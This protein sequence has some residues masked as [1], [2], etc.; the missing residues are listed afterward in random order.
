M[1][2]TRSG[3]VVAAMVVIALVF[4]CAGWVLAALEIHCLDVGQG[5]CTL[6]VS[7]TGGTLLFD[8][9]ENGKGTSEVRPYLQ[10]L[11]LTG[12]DYIAC[13]HYHV[14]HIGGIDEVVSYLGIDSVRVACYDRGWSYTTATYT[15]Y[16]NAVAPKR[17]T[18]SDSQVIDLGGGVTVTCVGL[19]GNGQ[20]SPPFDDKYDENDLCVALLVEY[21]GFKFFVAGDLSGT[22]SSSYHDIET[23]MGYEIGDIDVY[24]VDHHGSASNSNDTFLSTIEPEAAIISVGSNSYGH[25]TQTVINRLVNHDAYIY[26]TELGSGGTIPPGKGEVVGGDVVIIVDAGTYTIDGDVY[27]LAGSGVAGT[28]T[29]PSLRIFPNPFGASTT[30]SFAGAAAGPVR[31]GVYD[32]SGRLVSLLAGSLDATSTIVWNGESS[33]GKAVPPGVYFIRAESAAGTVSRKLVKR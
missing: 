3:F 25:P 14:D 10:S 24:R 2:A 1:K 17:L 15:S 22:N 5:D 26:Q 4:G 29:L 23:S 30:F 32:V 7:P 11:G 20:L 33:Q 13:S 8:A 12:L 16:A 9:G 18:I 19:N 31:V 28:G 6:I 21:Q 27:P